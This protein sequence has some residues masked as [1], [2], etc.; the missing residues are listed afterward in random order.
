MD[1]HDEKKPVRN[2]EGRTEADE[3]TG[4]VLGHRDGDVVVAG[5]HAEVSGESAAARQLGELKA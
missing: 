1:R 3:R 2:P 5:L 4:D